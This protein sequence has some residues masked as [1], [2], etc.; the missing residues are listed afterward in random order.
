MHIQP[1]SQM[2][3]RG[4]PF[5]PF[6]KIEKSVMIFGKKD[7]SFVHLW[8]K[9]SIQNVVFKSIWEKKLQNVSLWGL[10][11]LY[12]L[13]N[14]YR[15]ALVAW[16]LSCPEKFLVPCLHSGFILFAKCLILNIWQCSVYVLLLNNCSVISTVALCHVLHQRHSEFCHI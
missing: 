9:F 6:L 1:H 11:F 13:W 14:I 2:C 3:T 7:P 8:V 10:F 16:K 4:M 15:S 5:H 12:F